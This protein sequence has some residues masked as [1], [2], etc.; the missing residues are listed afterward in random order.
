MDDGRLRRSFLRRASQGARANACR[1]ESFRLR[2]FLSLHRT[3]AG[4]RVPCKR[5][6]FQVIEKAECNANIDPDGLRFASSTREEQA[7]SAARLVPKGGEKRNH[8][9][10]GFGAGRAVSKREGAIYK[11]RVGRHPDRALP[12]ALPRLPISSIHETCHVA[13]HPLRIPCILYRRK[14]GEP[15]TC[16]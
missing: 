15:E 8:H 6:G 14:I 7:S 1:P 3:I 11:G 16:P 4:G 9:G 2:P 13:R 5:R 10:I 12:G